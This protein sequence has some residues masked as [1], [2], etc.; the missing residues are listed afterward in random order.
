VEKVRTANAAL[1]V[2]LKKQIQ[3]LQSYAREQG[4]TVEEL[5][6]AIAELLPDPDAPSFASQAA[7]V[8]YRMTDDARRVRRLVRALLDLDFEGAS[9]NPL[10]EA[11]GVLRDLH[12]RRARHL[13]ESVDSSFAALWSVTID[14]SDR[15]RA[16]R[17]FETAILFELRKG[18]RNG[19]IWVPYSLSYRHREQLLIPS[20]EW[21][22]ARKR[23]YNHLKLP[24]D[25]ARYVVKYTRQ[26]EQGLEQVAEAVRTEVIGIE[27]DALVLDKLEAEPFSPDVEPVRDALFREIGTV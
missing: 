24:M 12:E 19:S 21:Q 3:Q 20:S 10:I 2:S 6:Q 7:E 22:E 1:G 16:L 8:G 9:N 4:R 25:P 14:G 5:R 11:V 27:K 13:P 26:L 23:Y 18:L 15:Q 17:G